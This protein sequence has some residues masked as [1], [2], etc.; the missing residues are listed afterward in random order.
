MKAKRSRSLSF[1]TLTVLVSC[2]FTASHCTAQTPNRTPHQAVS[3]F[4]NAI[5]MNDTNTAARLLESNTNLALARDNFSKQPLLEA[6][7]AGNLPLAK[8]LLELGADVNAAGDTLSSVGSERTALH[9]AIARN[10]P[11]LCKL[12]LESGADP[13]RMAFGYTTPLHLAFS[14]RREDLAALLLDHGA[15]AFR[16]KGFAN[17][18]PTPFEFA[19]VCGPGK[20]VPRMLRDV[21]AKPAA[22]QEKV[23]RILAARGVALLSTAAKRGELEAVEA[24]LA[25]SVPAKSETEDG[26]TVMQAFA[27]A[28][29]KAPDSSAER[30]SRIRE[31]L[32]KSGAQVDAFV[33]TGLGDEPAVR[34]L[35]SANARVAEARDAEKQ[36]PLHWAVQLDRTPMIAFWLGAGASPAATNAAGQ[37]PLH[38]AAR[39]GQVEPLKLLL[40]ASAPTAMR[41]TNGATPLDLAVKSKHTEIIRLLLGKESAGARPERGITQP[42]HKAAEAGNLTELGALANEKDKLDLRNELGLTP[43]AVAVRSGHLAAA[44]LLVDRG[45]DVNGR[46]PDGNTLLHQILL[47]HFYVHDRPPANWLSRVTDARRRQICSRFLIFGKDGEEPEA[48]LQ[49][50]SFLLAA[51]VDLAATNRAGRTATQLAAD[52]EATREAMIFDEERA[53]LL[54]L[55]SSSG[56][57]LNQADAEGNTP[58]H[59]AITDIFPERAEQLIEAGAEVNATNRLGRTPLHSAVEHLGHW[60]SYEDDEGACPFRS[61]LKHGANVNAQDNEGMTPLHVLA[62]SES[63]FKEQAVKALLAAGADPKI[64]DNHKRTVAHMFLS[65]EWPWSEAGECI[66]LLAARGVDLS[67]ADDQGQTLLHYLAKTGEHSSLF[68]LRNITNLLGGT[69]I[70]VMARDAEGDTPLHIAARAGSSDVLDWLSKRGANLD[71][72]NNAGETPRRI[73]AKNKDPF[74]RIRAS[75][76]TDIFRAIQQNKLDSVAALLKA[77]PELANDTDQ[78]GQTP[79]RMAANLR[80]TNIVDYLEQ[81]GARWDAY[82]AVLMGRDA[83]LKSILARDPKAASAAT[84]GKTPL[85]IAA[86]QG[87][88]TILQILIKAGADVNVPDN[89][90]RSP[91][92]CA[93]LAK[94]PPGV[95]DL[96]RSA[97]ATENIFDVV[98]AG[99]AE[100]AS[101]LLAENPS[102][103]LATNRSLVAVA[104]IAAGKSPV[105]LLQQLL[106]KGA[107]PDYVNPQTGRSLLHCAAAANQAEAAE[108]L[109]QLGISPTTSDKQGFQPLHLAALN[110][111]TEAAAVLLRHKA[112]VNAMTVYA[113]D[114]ARM[115][116]MPMR[117]G[118]GLAG[119]SVLHLAAM[120]GRTNMIRVL[121]QS[122]AAVNATNS[123][124][125]TALDLAGQPG[126]PF[127]FFWLQRSLGPT[128]GEDL[129]PAPLQANPMASLRQR[130]NAA[131]SLLEQAGGTRAP[132]VR[133]NFGP[134]GY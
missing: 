4:F 129:L 126:M 96:L 34:Q 27:R 49:A 11:D 54:K 100:L 5:A 20:L 91:L 37:T 123:S 97:G 83:P 18:H 42:I 68:F 117:D 71:A 112:A 118:R 120:F 35:T 29:A 70:N 19:V 32:E 28:A 122:G 116:M 98:Y 24:L 61:L 133:S 6:A 92:G 87:D 115:M 81:H 106:Q 50:A 73:A 134:P 3:A 55:L 66:T 121:L 44:A 114:S 43:L 95:T 128:G 46:D 1:V 88:V 53:E 104:E 38:I 64:V 21:R 127:P 15:D 58:L 75:A 130:Q 23:N 124:G 17:Y 51:G 105:A 47:N 7:A 82:S 69:N 39:S 79:L 9:F 60:G 80:N 67:A 57:N 59:L 113:P 65:G 111:A 40:A 78:V 45:A 131:A 89:S 31:L 48:V 109:L 72:T 14:E 8:R 101:G 86:A 125:S 22:E 110:D 103:A 13:N 33:A 119:N 36:T 25:A 26:F 41:D 84:F 30:W 99:D 108:L 62:Q 2:A 74:S 102:F 77:D 94:Q 132:R 107:K 85:H 16:E 52:E 93:R 12:L 76:D 90:G 56:G 10:H 63:S